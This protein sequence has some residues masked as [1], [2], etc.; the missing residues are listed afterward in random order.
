MVVNFT[1]ITQLSFNTYL[2]MSNYM[3][4][5]TFKEQSISALSIYLPIYIHLYICLHSKC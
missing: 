4:E 2:L 5:V 1:S 3:N